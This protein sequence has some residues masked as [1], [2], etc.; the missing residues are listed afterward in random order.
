ME[1]YWKENLQTV[2]TGTRLDIS[3]I[4]F[5]ST[6]RPL[7]SYFSKETIVERNKV[8]RTYG[9]LQRQEII[10]GATAVRLLCKLRQHASRKNR[11]ASEYLAEVGDTYF[12][13]SDLEQLE[14]IHQAKAIAGI[15]MI[16]DFSSLE[17]W[18]KPWEGGGR[19]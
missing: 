15:M 11:A 17:T 6:E 9:T 16:L 7:L 14:K 19:D 2:Y 1:G 5:P 4:K 8:V 3:Y 12:S 10:D 18:I 13:Y